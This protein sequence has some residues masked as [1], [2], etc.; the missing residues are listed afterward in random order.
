MDLVKKWW[1]SIL[2]AI[3]ALWGVFGTSIQL[4][5]SSHPK[6]TAVFAAL[7]VII[8]HL[9]PSPVAQPVVGVK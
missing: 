4:A 5:V 6:L 3:G 7:A 9:V 2:A 8:A 1:P